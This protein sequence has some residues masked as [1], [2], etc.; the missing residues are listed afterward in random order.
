MARLALH[1]GGKAFFDVK[2]A[3][4]GDA[5]YAIA[6]LRIPKS[7]HCSGFVVYDEFLLGRLEEARRLL[8]GG[9]LELSHGTMRF[10]LSLNAHARFEVRCDSGA[11]CVAIEA[12]PED[13]SGKRFIAR[14]ASIVRAMIKRS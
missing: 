10:S 11:G 5:V 4:R 9:S 1:K 13:G 2:L 8:G 3:R 7:Q 6:G 14:L 12:T